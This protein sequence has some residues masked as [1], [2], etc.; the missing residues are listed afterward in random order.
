MA[1]DRFPE[2]HCENCDALMGEVSLDDCEFDF[3][4]GG[5]PGLCFDC[6]PDSADTVPSLFWQWQERDRF[7]IDDTVFTVWQNGLQRVRTLPYSLT[8]MR[9]VM[10]RG[11][12]SS[13]YLNNSTVE[14]SQRDKEILSYRMCR[15]CKSAVLDCWSDGWHCPNC[16]SFERYPSTIHDSADVII[17]PDWIIGP[18]IQDGEYCLDCRRVN[19]RVVRYCDYHNLLFGS[20]TLTNIFGDQS[21]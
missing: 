2:L 18:Q 3:D 9:A 12:S 1:T 4:G 5:G 13:T 14:R 10:T 8:R 19:G 16:K 17:I 21:V 20:Q 7:F 11:L 15:E 6:D